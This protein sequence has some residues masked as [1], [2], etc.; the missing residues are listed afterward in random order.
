MSEFSNICPV[1]S[2]C[3]GCGCCLWNV[4]SLSCSSGLEAP[5]TC[6]SP[7]SHSHFCVLRWPVYVLSSLSGERSLE[8]GSVLYLI[9]K[10]THALTELALSIWASLWLSSF[11]CK[12]RIMLTESS[13]KCIIYVDL[14]RGY[15]LLVEKP[16]HCSYRKRENKFLRVYC[17][18]FLT[19]LNDWYI[20]TKE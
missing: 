4:C 9:G 7:H 20:Y 1:K 16:C 15:R 11:V 10:K 8:I 6:F 17:S 14:I 3:Q 2:C 12:I 18:S 13:A 19:C 5:E